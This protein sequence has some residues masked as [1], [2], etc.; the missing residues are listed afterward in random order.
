MIDI[1]S[2]VVF[3]VDD[4]ARTLE[5]SLAMLVDAASG[6][7]TDIVA[8]PHANLEYSFDPTEISSKLQQLREA[9]PTDVRIHTGCDFHLD[10]DLI[11]D[12]IAHPQKYSINHGPYLLIELSEEIDLK[13]IP[14]ILNRLM[15]C[16]LIPIL[17]H[18]ERYFVL[19]DQ[20]EEIQS[21]VTQGCLVQVTAQSMLGVFGSKAKKMSQKLLDQHLVHFIASDAHDTKV[22]TARMA[23]SR[24]WV[25]DA[26]GAALAESLF[27]T[28]PGATLTGEPLPPQVRST[29]KSGSWFSF[30]KS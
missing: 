17:T 26:Y 25:H 23:E 6:G 24:D 2:H 9:N 30:W 10:Y 5:E 14:S 18:P 11:Q 8:T 15:R 12:A 28:N 7:T 22:R 1:H 29:Q 20:M 27:V 4:G 3:G 19:R 13:N 16:G 21:W